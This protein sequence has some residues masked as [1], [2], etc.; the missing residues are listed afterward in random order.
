MISIG[1]HHDFSSFIR[2]KFKN[3][4]LAQEGMYLEHHNGIPAKCMESTISLINQNINCRTTYLNSLQFSN[5][6]FLFKKQEIVG[7]GLS[8]TDYEKHELKLE[9]LVAKEKGR[10]IGSFLL[11]LILEFARF[12]LFTLVVLESVENSLNFYKRHAGGGFFE[13]NSY[14]NLLSAKMPFDPLKINLRSQPKYISNKWVDLNYSKKITFNACG[15]QAD[16][17]EEVK[18]YGIEVE[19]GGNKICYRLFS[20]LGIDVKSRLLDQEKSQLLISDIKSTKNPNLFDATLGLRM[21]D[22]KPTESP[23]VDIF[24]EDKIKSLSF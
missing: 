22:K 18:H 2:E 12:N 6:I 10:G 13:K 1:F 19:E 15:V 9:Y 7:V 16:E 4:F 5:C 8:K 3:N 23:G 24:E 14:G 17:C 21:L 20:N 11:A